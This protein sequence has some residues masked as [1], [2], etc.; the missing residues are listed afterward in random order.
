MDR[1]GTWGPFWGSHC[2]ELSATV[3]IDKTTAKQKSRISTQQVYQDVRFG[4]RSSTGAYFLLGLL[5]GLLF[6]AMS[7][8][9]PAAG[10]PFIAY[11]ARAKVPA[12]VPATSNAYPS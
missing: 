6:E 12:P 10:W 9:G 3:A 1:K 7:L 2:T 11:E 4:L 5:L 8:H